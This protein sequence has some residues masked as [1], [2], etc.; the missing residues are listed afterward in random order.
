MSAHPFDLTGKL[1]LVT[2]AAKGIG[3]G[4]AWVLA[5]AGAKVLVVDVDV[6]GAQ[7]KALELGN[8]SAAVEMNLADEA[9]IVAACVDAFAQH[10]APWALVNNAGVQDRQLLLEGTAAEWD[11][12]MVV[13]TRAPFLL[14][15]EVA[16]AMVAAGAGGRIVHIASNAVIGGITAGH[17]IYA[18]S[19]TALM[20]L[21]RASALELA[22]HRITVNTVMP[23]GVMTPG[24]MA[25]KGP[26]PLGPGRR[27][28]PLGMASPED[29]GAAVLFLASPAAAKVTNQAFAVD[30]GWT[31]S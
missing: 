10:G 30:G 17:A 23:G 31:V 27:M 20:G 21:M 5:G 8:G 11:R 1:V 14:S 22:E 16:R 15:R 25:A 7:A 28:P 9:S 18:S 3:G 13:N 29:I 19:K 26:E 12:T 2:G 4:I 6:A 24:A